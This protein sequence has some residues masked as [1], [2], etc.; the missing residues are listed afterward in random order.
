MQA[1]EMAPQSVSLPNIFICL[2]DNFPTVALLL[3]TQVNFGSVATKNCLKIRVHATV[4]T[5][6][7]QVIGYSILQVTYYLYSYMVCRC[8]GGHLGALLYLFV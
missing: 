5:Q 1:T 6:S 4:N 2:Q 3:T 7:D 8:L